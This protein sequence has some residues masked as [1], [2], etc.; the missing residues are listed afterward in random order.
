MQ[1]QNLSQLTIPISKIEQPST[2]LLPGEIGFQLLKEFFY[3][4]RYAI[5]KTI[6]E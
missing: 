4:Y 5:E 1:C 2:I 6:S 3:G